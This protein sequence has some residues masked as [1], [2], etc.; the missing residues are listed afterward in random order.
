MIAAAM[1]THVTRASSLLGERCAPAG[2][3]IAFY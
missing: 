3:S 1:P 2:G